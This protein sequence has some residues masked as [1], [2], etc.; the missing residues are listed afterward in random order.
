MKRLLS[1]PRTYVA[2]PILLAG[3]LAATYAGDPYVFAMAVLVLGA[4]TVLLG[5]AGLF[6]VL[7]GPSATR[8]AK[9]AVLVSW[10]LAVGMDLLAMAVLR[11]VRWG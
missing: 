5:G 1:E 3:V 11:S 7:R 8:P 2:W 10:L 9:A 6:F 4:M